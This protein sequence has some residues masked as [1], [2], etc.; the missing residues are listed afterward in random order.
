M[1]DARAIGIAGIVKTN[2]GATIFITQLKQ[3]YPHLSRSAQNTIAAMLQGIVSFDVPVNPDIIQVLPIDPSQVNV[4]FQGTGSGYTTQ[5]DPVIPDKNLTIDPAASALPDSLIKQIQNGGSI[6]V[7]K[8][9]SSMASFNLDTTTMI[10][11]G[12]AALGAYIVYNK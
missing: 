10:F 9:G 6:T 11:V 4:K 12:L 3:M 5:T 1:E 8:S 2:P 7:N